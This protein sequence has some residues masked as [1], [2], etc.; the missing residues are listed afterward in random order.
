MTPKEYFDFTSLLIDLTLPDFLK[1]DVETTES[2]EE[3]LYPD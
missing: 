1:A 3:S 2:F